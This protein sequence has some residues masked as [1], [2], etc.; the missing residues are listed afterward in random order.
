MRLIKYYFDNKKQ[1]QLINIDYKTEEI[2]P[3]YVEKFPVYK[4]NTNK[5]IDIQEI[6]KIYYCNL[7]EKKM[8]L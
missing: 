7:I 1:I 8:T 2:Y 4:N 6:I 5:I 3:N